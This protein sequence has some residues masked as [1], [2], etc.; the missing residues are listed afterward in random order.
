MTILSCGGSRVIKK[1]S[2]TMTSHS[3]QCIAC[4]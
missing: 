4:I 3:T 2:E 1:V